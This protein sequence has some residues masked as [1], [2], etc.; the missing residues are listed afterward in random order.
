M[1]RPFVARRLCQ[2][3]VAVPQDFRLQP[4]QKSGANLTDFLRLNHL[5]NAALEKFDVL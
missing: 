3:G 2:S 1:S 5:R 4:P